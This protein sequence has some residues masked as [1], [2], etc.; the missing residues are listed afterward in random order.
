[1]NPKLVLLRVTGYGQSGPYAVYPSFGR[2]A[3][4]FGSISFLSGDP[5]RPPAQP[6]SATL[7]D[8]LAGLFGA[9]AIR[10]PSEPPTRPGA[11]K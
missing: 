7:A 11:A 5:D 4:A 10:S 1:V 9:Y 6:G 2:I 3:N 8:Y